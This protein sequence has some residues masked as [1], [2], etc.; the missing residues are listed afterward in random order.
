MTLN[1]I[2]KIACQLFA[3]SCFGF[4]SMIDVGSIW[5]TG[6]A[7]TAGLQMPGDFPRSPGSCCHETLKSLAPSSESHPEKIT[8]SFK[9]PPSEAPQPWA[10]PSQTKS[11]RKE[12]EWRTVPSKK[13]LHTCLWV[14]FFFFPKVLKLAYIH[15]FIKGL[16]H[17]IFIH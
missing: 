15:L 9:P 7:K 17:D 6:A 8:T 10:A 5:R 11:E 14:S 1:W 16:H 2:L 13:D 3:R 4:L 12:T